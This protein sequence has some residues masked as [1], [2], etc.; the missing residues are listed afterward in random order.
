MVNADVVVSGPGCEGRTMPNPG[1][2]VSLAQTLA[3]GLSVDGAFYVRALDGRPLARIE[4]RGTTVLTFALDR[5]P[6]D[7]LI[8]NVSEG[9]SL[10]TQETHKGA[11][12]R[13]DTPANRA[14]CGVTSGGSW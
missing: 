8:P 4:R 14:F 7:L 9:S 5:D 13:R 3:S 1:A 10:R 6:S 11:T 12:H 2:G